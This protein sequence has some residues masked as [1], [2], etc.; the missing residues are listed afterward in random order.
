MVL[1]LRS[2]GNIV[3][4]GKRIKVDKVLCNWDGT[5]YIPIPIVW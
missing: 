2:H 1:N 4:A 3:N 5:Y